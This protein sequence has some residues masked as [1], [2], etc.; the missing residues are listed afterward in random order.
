MDKQLPKS[1]SFRET[2]S[3][4]QESTLHTLQILEWSEWGDR[5]VEQ[6]YKLYKQ[7]NLC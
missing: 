2:F 7:V 1:W 5:L 3:E 6:S 4:L